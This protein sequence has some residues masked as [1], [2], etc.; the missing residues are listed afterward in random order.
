MGS[1]NL[2]KLETWVDASHTVHKETRGNIG[3]CMSFGVCII[4]G[5]ESEQ[6]LNTKITTESEAVSVSEYVP[7]KVQTINIFWDKAMLYRK[8]VLYQYNTHAIKME[9]NGSNSCK[10][11][12]REISI[13]YFFFEDSG[14]KEEFSIKYCNTS[15]MI[16]DFFD[17]LLKGSL[18]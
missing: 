2:L 15:V 5:K 3:G 4:H 9:K 14:D 17:K 6:K 10:G 7:Y 16:A 1:E 8:K 18:F 13:R 12:S 11:N